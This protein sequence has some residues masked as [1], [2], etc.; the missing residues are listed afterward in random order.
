MLVS[1]IQIFFFHASFHFSGLYGIPTLIILGLVSCHS[2]KWQLKFKL[3]PITAANKYLPHLKSYKSVTDKIYKEIGSHFRGLYGE[4]AG[5]AHSVL[6][7]ADLKHLQTN[8]GSPLKNN[9]KRKK[10]TE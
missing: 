7:S 2:S 10:C 8:N 6:F 1:S 5:W 3:F 4:Y 9:R